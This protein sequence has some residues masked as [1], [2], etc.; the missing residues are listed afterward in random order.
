MAENEGGTGGSAVFG[1][2]PAPKVPMPQKGVVVG[3]AWSGLE[4]AGNQ[5]VA[6]RIE[7]A[8]GKAKLT[9]VWRPFQDA[10]GRRDV[11]KQF[12]TWLAEEVRWAEGKLVIGSDFPLSLAET[13]L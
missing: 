5:I 9:Q 6:A 4:G 13:H 2:S 10:P 3:L 11:L 12:P 7:L 8:R 1:R